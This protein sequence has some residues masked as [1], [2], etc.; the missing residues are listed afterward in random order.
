MECDK[1]GKMLPKFVFPGVS[2]VMSKIKNN[3]ML[4]DDHKNTLASF[5]DKFITV[6]IDNSDTEAIVRQVNIHYHTKTCYKYGSGKCRFHFPKFPTDKTIISVP[7]RY[8]TS[9]T[10]LEITENEQMKRFKAYQKCLQEMKKILENEDVM[11]RIQTLAIDAQINKTCTLANVKRD[12]YDNA[13]TYSNNCYFVHYKRKPSERFVN[14]Y[15]KEWLK[16]WDGNMDMQ[17]CLDYFAVVS[18]ITDYVTKT[19]NQL[20]QQLVKVV[21]ENPGSLTEKMKLIK[22]T[23][24]AHRQVGEAELFYRIL[25][26]LHLKDSN[27]HCIFVSTGFPE[28]RSRFLQKAF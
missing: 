6:E 21:K 18:Y 23:F 9:G 14:T 17:V 19:D 20:M 1:E 13:L 27:I 22:D 11:K 25:P 16:A 24:L 4:S 10:G 3:K 26:D 12:E 8:M 2:D 7:Y 15:N 5:I 28:N